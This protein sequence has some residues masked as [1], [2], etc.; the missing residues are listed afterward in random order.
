MVAKKG[1]R[2]GWALFAQAPPSL[3]VTFLVCCLVVNTSC[4]VPFAS[5]QIGRV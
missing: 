4:D 5:S 2:L 1:L 3:V